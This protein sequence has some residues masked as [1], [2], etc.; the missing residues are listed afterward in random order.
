MEVPIIVS[1]T[2]YKAPKNDELTA[3]FVPPR[4]NPVLKPTLKHWMVSVRN[5]VSE[6]YVIK[7]NK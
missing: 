2:W 7:M 4:R 3:S 1:V 6:V 5:A